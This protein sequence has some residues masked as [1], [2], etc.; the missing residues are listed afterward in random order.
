MQRRVR[1]FRV[2]I[3]KQES[4]CLQ[5][6]S[7][8]LVQ[9][10]NVCSPLHLN[11]RTVFMLSI[12]K[13]WTLIYEH[14]MQIIVF[15][16]LNAEGCL[17]LH[18]EINNQSNTHIHIEHLQFQIPATKFRVGAFVVVFS[19]SFFSTFCKQ[20]RSFSYVVDG[21]DGMFTLL[22][23]LFYILQTFINKDIYSAKS[24]KFAFIYP[25]TPWAVNFFLSVACTVRL[26]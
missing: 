22:L 12:P 4:K 16:C 8:P 20:S 21:I 17:T 3:W 18:I 6:I 5:Y 9:L 2:Q 26:K 11:A 24:L 13:S 7:F 25:P 23:F 15:Y 14:E 19:L 10:K 1:I